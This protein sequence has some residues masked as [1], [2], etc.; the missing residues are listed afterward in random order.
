MLSRFVDE[1]MSYILT[2]KSMWMPIN[3]IACVYSNI[4]EVEEEKK[5]EKVVVKKKK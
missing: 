4:P 3:L 2:P 5:V 1:K